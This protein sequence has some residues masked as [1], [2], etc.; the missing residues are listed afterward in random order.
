MQNKAKELRALTIDDIQELLANINE[1]AFRAQQ[2]WDW[3]WKKN[4]AS[5]DEMS[6][7]SNTLR[8]YL[9]ENYTIEP[10]Q[11]L[12]LKKSTDKTIKVVFKLHDETFIE[13]VLIPSA[14]RVT[15]CISSQV[16]CTLGCKFCATGNMGFIRNLTAGEIVDQIAILKKTSEKEYGQNLSNIVY[17]GMGEPLQNYDNVL[18]SINN[19]TSTKG[20]GMSPSRITLSTVGLPKMI[21]KLADDDVKFNLAISLHTAH[22]TKRNELM[23]INISQ[24]LDKL[25]EAIK[26]F[27]KKTGTRVTFEYVMLHKVNDSVDDAKLLASFCRI[28]PCKVNIIEFNPFDGCIYQTSPSNR[29]KEFAELLESKNMVV[30]IRQ[31]RGKD[32]DAAC[33]Q[34]A[35]KY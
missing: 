9:K 32:I 26:Y 27:H 23:P 31:S 30:N 35:N 7:L 3:L 13:G 25:S 20:W 24:P 5:I 17:M 16:G 34:L 1:K 15:A 10:A 11:L 19:I 21:K 33:G 6:N 2:I 18:M 8:N 4:V 29:V 28:V 12:T 22:S 14:D